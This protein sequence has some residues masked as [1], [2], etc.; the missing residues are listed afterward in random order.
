[1]DE[2]RKHVAVFNA[3]VV[4]L[5]V[6]VRGNNGRKVASVLFIV[7]V[8]QSINHALSQGIPDVAVMRRTQMNLFLG[9]GIF[10]LVRKDARGEARD[11]FLDFEPNGGRVLALRYIYFPFMYIGDWQTTTTTTITTNSLQHSMTMSFMIMFSLKNS[12][13][14]DWFAYSPPTYS[15]RTK[16]RVEP[17]GAM[18]EFLEK[19]A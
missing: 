4:G 16:K 19:N 15:S 3:E 10:H 9:Q 2:T 1:V 5:A 8:V 17:D 6:D 18:N 13:F 7:A 14:C 11:E 12:T